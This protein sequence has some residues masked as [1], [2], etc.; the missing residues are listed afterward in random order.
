MSETG[1]ALS[2]GKFNARIEKALNESGLSD[3]FEVSSVECMGACES[4]VAVAIQGQGRAT[5]LFAGVDPENDVQDMIATCR[6]Y[7]GSPNGW[8]EDAR[9]CGRLRELL[10]SRVPALN[11]D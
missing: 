11:A 10:R 2:H 6:T 8:I 4:P 9:A 3:L 1:K 5:Y 7:L